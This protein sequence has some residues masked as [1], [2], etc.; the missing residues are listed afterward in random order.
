MSDAKVLVTRGRER[1]NQET[2]IRARAPLRI[3]FVGGGTDIPQYYDEHGGAVLSATINRYSHVSLYPRVDKEVRVRSLDLGTSVKYAIDEEPMYDG[4]L[5]LAKAAIRRMGSEKG[6][7][8]DVDTEAPPGSGLGGSSAVTAAILGAIAEYTGV[9]VDE[10]EMAEIDF[11]VERL[12][13]GVAGGKQDQYATVFGGFNVIEFHRDR[14]LVTPLRLSRD[15]LSDLEHHL[16]LCYTG[17]VRPSLGLVERQ[18]TS[19]HE[20]KAETLTRLARAKAMVLEMKEALLKRRLV[21]VG[22]LLEESFVTKVRINPEVT[23]ARIDELYQ[24]A[25][26]AGAVGGKLLGA[27]GGG[28]LLLFVQ[29]DRRHAV[30]EALV[31]AGGQ[32]ATF[33]FQDHGLQAWRSTCR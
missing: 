30:R 17:T 29:G 16:I 5:D 2:I 22:E 11:A 6:F 26:T 1:V 8:L 12:D 10:Y 24:E 19:L 20:G 31:K 21:R 33:S 23:N 4:V 7:E 25:K 15:L 9:V 13:L 32:L 27:G 28:Y 14:V 3:S 18:V